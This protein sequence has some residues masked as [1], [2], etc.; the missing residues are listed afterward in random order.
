M[1]AQKPHPPGAGGRRVSLP[2]LAACKNNPGMPKAG[3]VEK[4][5][6]PARG[7][8]ELP[9]QQPR[10]AQPKARALLAPRGPGAVPALGA[11]AQ[12]RVPQ[13]QRARGTLELE[14]GDSDTGT[15]LGWKGPCGHAA[16]TAPG[17]THRHVSAPH[18]AATRRAPGAGKG[19]P[20]HPHSPAQDAAAGSVPRCAGRSCSGVRGLGPC[21]ETRGSPPCRAPSAGAGTGAPRWPQAAPGTL[22]AQ[23]AGAAPKPQLL[24][25][26]LTAGV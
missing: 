5:Q 13:G 14:P 12:G 10:A 6:D 21:A 3:A 24:L 25:S 2:A 1:Q 11:K 9:S 15:A 16:S 22:T 7:G 18:V 8:S 23:G 20:A 17:H 4:Q 19:Q 26:T